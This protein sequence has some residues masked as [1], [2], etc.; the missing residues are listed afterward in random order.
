MSF[1]SAVDITVM[2]TEAFNALAGSINGLTG[3]CFGV[4]GSVIGANL[5]NNGDCMLLNALAF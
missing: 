5:N 1:D 2:M 4:L 3:L